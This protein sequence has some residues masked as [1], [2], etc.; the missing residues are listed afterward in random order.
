MKLDSEFT[1]KVGTGKSQITGNANSQVNESA[2]VDG[3]WHNL[4]H[5]FQRR[6]TQRVISFKNLTEEQ[7][8]TP[9]NAISNA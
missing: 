7:N 1:W 8:N 6:F 5:G 3:R 9:R 2:Q 4:I